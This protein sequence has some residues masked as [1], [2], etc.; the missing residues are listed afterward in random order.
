MRNLTLC[1]LLVATS[2]A[3]HAQIAQVQ[4]RFLGE[5]EA[6]Q[7]FWSELYAGGGETLYCGESFADSEGLAISALYSVREIRQALRCTTTNQCAVQT[8][9]YLNM[10]GDLHNLYP[11]EA[12]FEERRRGDRFGEAHSAPE[13][14]ECGVR[15]GFKLIEPPARAKG[16]VARALLHMHAEYDLPLPVPLSLLGRWHQEDPADQHERIR[17]DRIAVLQ[18]TRNRFIDDPAQA[19]RLAQR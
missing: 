3:A 5:E 18:G 11:N 6:E 10:V 9:R 2:L 15:T 8:P 16:N 1:L 17:N 14:G 13:P 4:S 12:R 7:A 19:E